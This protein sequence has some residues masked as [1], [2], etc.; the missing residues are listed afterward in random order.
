M[1]FRRLTIGD[2]ENYHTLINEFRPT[3][4][5]RDD[6][7][8]YV[9]QMPSCNEVW[10]IEDAGML[11]A[12][13]TI[14]FERKLIFNMALYAHIEDICVASS[15]RHYGIG[16]QLLNLIISRCHEMRCH[17]ISLVCN[18]KIKEFYT[19]NGFEERGIQCSMLCRD[20]PATPSLS[21]S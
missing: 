10:V 16:S 3:V 15:R 11:I 7:T 20:S 13:G 5:S 12:T 6:F 14:I 21:I 9:V 18:A 17:K 2:H 4:F 1:I 8:N 19:S